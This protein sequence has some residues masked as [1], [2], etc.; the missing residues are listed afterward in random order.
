VTARYF[1]LGAGRD[2]AKAMAAYESILR[3]D[4]VVA[5]MVNLGEILRS[6]REFARAESLNVAA[7]R[8]TPQNGTAYG[9]AIEIMLDQGKTK[10]AAEL[11]E[12]LKAVSPKYAVARRTYLLSAQGDDRAARAL[13]DSTMKLGGEARERIGIDGTRAFALMD[14]RL[15]DFEAATKEAV[16]NASPLSFRRVFP[17]MVDIQI[18]G[19]TPA[20]AARL[21]SAIARAPLREF[22][23]VDRPYLDMA[24]AYALAGM[25]D[26]ARAMIARYE[27]EMTDTSLR[28]V[29]QPEFH[30]TL[31]EL[32]LANNKPLEAIEEFRRADVTYDGAPANDCASC[33]SFNLGRAFDAAGKSDS[34]AVMFERYLATPGWYKADSEMDP[35]RVP[36]IR[37]RLGQLYES[38]GKTDKA[39]ENYR[40]FIDLWKNA[41]PELQPRVADAKRR[42]AKLT[43]VEKPRP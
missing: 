36:A 17:L 8:M 31:A 30:N 15:R 3:T 41:D 4:S 29:Q 19:P 35:L 28:R 43:P 34:A 18:K 12:R 13:V 1:W 32:A 14:G 9:N 24:T 16:A 10:E 37:E 26:K 11:V 2:R 38:M 22:P 27:S 20:N 7:I 39:V 25:P 42:L 23:M 5:V 21:D 6:R 33:L 40:A